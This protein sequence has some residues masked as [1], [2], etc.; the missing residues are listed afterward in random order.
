MLAELAAANAAFAVIKQA[1]SNGSDLA[2]CAS[3]IGQVVGAKEQLEK[4]VKKKKATHKTSDFEEFMALERIREQE[5]NL[6]QIMIWAGRP[7]LL[8]DWQKFQKD[9]R[10]ARRNAE[11][12]AQRRRQKII[13]YIFIF[14][15][16]CVILG[17]VVCLFW[18]A[19][20]LKGWI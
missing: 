6:K 16:F 12:A 18:W 13:E 8:A 10:V 1:I 2:R 11:I 9:A 20:W 7:G 3:Q 15:L 19:L 5:E 14:L 17:A 4:K